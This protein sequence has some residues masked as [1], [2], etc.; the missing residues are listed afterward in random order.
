MLR[1]WEDAR[2]AFDEGRIGGAELACLYVAERVQ[3]IA[4]KRWLQGPRKAVLPIGD[5]APE[6]VRQMAARELF[7]LPPAAPQALVAWAAGLRPV[8]LRFDIPT[9]RQLLAMQAQGRRV[10]SLLD[11]AVAPPGPKASYGGR[12]ASP[13][14]G[15]VVHDLCHLEKFVDPAHHLGQVGFFAA[16]DGALTEGAFTRVEAGF[17]AA[18]IDERDHVLADMNGSAVFLFVVL[19]NKA[20]IAVRRRVARERGEACRAGP[21]DEGE[22]CAYAEAVEALLDALGL[23]EEARAAARKLDAKRADDAEAASCLLAAFEARGRA[24]LT[25]ASA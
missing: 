4:G 3:R 5:D 18:W 15:F 19:R 7:G 12:G 8:E 1:S 17:D 16:L 2:A 21:L 14:L 9:P 25:S 10:V 11:D 23:D 22:L 6:I 20:K 13:G 24:M